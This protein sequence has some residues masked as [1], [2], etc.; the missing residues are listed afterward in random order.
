MKS[1]TKHN[2]KPTS[3]LLLTTD[4]TCESLKAKI[5]AADNQMKAIKSE[6]ESM[7][8]KHNAEAQPCNAM[9]Q[10]IVKLGNSLQNG[11]MWMQQ[12]LFNLNCCK[13]DLAMI[14]ADNL[15]LTVKFD[16]L[17]QMDQKENVKLFFY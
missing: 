12:T 14:K 13:E 8:L 10:R 2:K 5:L 3:S 7:K 6:I 9:Q 17:Q 16:L 1:Q 4:E 11:E 15:E